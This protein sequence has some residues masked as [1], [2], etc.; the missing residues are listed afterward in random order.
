MDDGAGGA[1][2]AYVNTKRQKYADLIDF[3]RY[4]FVPFILEVQGGI[5]D[6]TITFIRGL[7][8]RERQKTSF[9][10]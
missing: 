7:M 1:A 5:G 9:F 10:I 6:S 4:E 3:E 2:T 8:K